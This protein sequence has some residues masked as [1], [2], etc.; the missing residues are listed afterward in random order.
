MPEYDGKPQIL[1]NI[2]SGTYTFIINDKG[3]FAADHMD[4]ILD[5][6]ESHT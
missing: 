6:G 3:E 2:K 4:L 5:A 1:E